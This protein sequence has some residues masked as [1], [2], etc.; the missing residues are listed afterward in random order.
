VVLT[1]PPPGPDDAPPADPEEQR[2]LGPHPGRYAVSVRVLQGD[3]IPMSETGS[4]WG[5]PSRL[6]YT[7][8]QHFEPVDTIGD[9]IW[10]FDIPL[11]EANRVRARLGLVSL[12]QP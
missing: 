7:Y 8:F 5:L 4:E 12:E 3:A 9:S 1:L 6:A 2:R 10:V 11:E